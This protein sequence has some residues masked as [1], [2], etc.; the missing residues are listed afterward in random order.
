MQTVAEK[1]SLVLKKK[2][3]KAFQEVKEVLTSNY[4]LAH[5]ESSTDLILACDSSPYS[6]GAILSHHYSNGEEKPITFASHSL[7]VA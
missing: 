1:C 4:V 7:V 3:K 5:S 2:Q 6:A